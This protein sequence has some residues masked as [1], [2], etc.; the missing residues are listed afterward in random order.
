MYFFSNFIK[1]IISVKEF[2]ESE[3]GFQQSRY[4]FPIECDYLNK[5]SL[6]SIFPNNTVMSN[7]LLSQLVSDNSYDI[8][9]NKKHFN[10]VKASKII[11]QIDELKSKG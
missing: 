10:L 2:V 6:F 1:I 5:N 8:S 7:D 4:L 3:A 11:S 9:F